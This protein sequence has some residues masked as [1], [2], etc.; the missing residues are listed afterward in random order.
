[1]PWDEPRAAVPNQGPRKKR[2]HIYLHEDRKAFP[3]RPRAF[4]F[5]DLYY[6]AV[7]INREKLLE[8]AQK[9]VE[10]KKYDKAVIELRR[11]VEADP[12]DA[13]TLHKIAELQAKQGLYA[14]AI[15]TYESVGKLYAGG[16]FALKAVAVYK[17]IRE[18]LAG[19]VPQLDGRYGHIAPKLADLYSELGLT[20]DALA[21]LTEVAMSLQSQ[22][23]ESELIAV[24]RKIAALDPESPLPHL[25]LAEALSRARDSAGAVVSFR[26]AASLLVQANRRDDALQVLE[27]LLHHQPDPEQARICAELYLSRARPPHD[28]MQA[29]AKLQ[30]CIQ[31]SPRDLDIL[32]LVARAFEMIGQK[33]KAIEIQQEIAR[34]A[35]TPR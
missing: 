24:L 21:L 19:H 32:T 7:A 6:R 31:A 33:A 12:H 8:A 26:T 14:E 11:L 22:Q 34:I 3:A 30:I 18:I 9:Y 13:R 10:K 27:R 35:R 4:V 20:S 16:G 23:K 17:L 5:S 29:L 15:D 28:G 25:R 2:A 1:M